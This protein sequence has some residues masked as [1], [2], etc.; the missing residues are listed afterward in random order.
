MR[1]GNDRS[2]KTIKFLEQYAKLCT[3]YDRQI[4]GA[5]NIEGE[6]V[7]HVVADAP[8]AEDVVIIKTLP[9]A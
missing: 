8:N 1:T 3:K 2:V 4:D 6:I 5:R 7:L 9:E